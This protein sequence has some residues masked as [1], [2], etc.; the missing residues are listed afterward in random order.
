MNADRE[1]NEAYQ[2]W[3]R[4]SEMEGEAIGTTNWNMVSACQ[5]AL[6]ILQERITRLTPQARK[7]WCRSG[8]DLAGREKALKT[9][10]YDL[11]KIQKRN[12]TL[13]Q[14]LKEAARAKIDSLGLANRNLQQIQNSYHLERSPTWT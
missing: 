5:K 4:L 1:L 13:L 14:S 9:T 12:H 11:I 7:E 3:R 6:Q 10:I 2:E 8:A